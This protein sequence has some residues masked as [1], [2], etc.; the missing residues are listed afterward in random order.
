[1]RDI[2]KDHELRD[3]T[4]KIFDEILRNICMACC[5][6]SNTDACVDHEGCWV[7]N[8]RSEISGKIAEILGFKK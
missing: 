4:L 1:M 5:I 2:K 8:G 7:F 3:N 6:D